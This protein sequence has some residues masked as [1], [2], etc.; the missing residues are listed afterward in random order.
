MKSY[1]QLFKQAKNAGTEL[2]LLSEKKINELLELIAQKTEKNI[3][4][5]LS[6]N[7]K[8]LEKMDPILPKYDRLLLNEQR[9]TD[10][11]SD[12]HKV[13]SLPYPVGKI[14]AKRKLD[15]GLQLSKISV[16]FGVIGIIFESRPNVCFDVFSL[17]LKSGNACILKG[18]SE[19][20]YSN[21][22]ISEII[23]STLKEKNINPD[24]CTL[25]PNDRSATEQLLTAREYVDLII[26]RGGKELINF[27][28][29]NS[30]IP[31]IETGAGVCHTYFHQEG[32]KE[33]GKNIIT[34]AKTRKVSVCN[35]LDCLIIDKYRLPDLAY[36]CKDLMKQNVLIYADDLAY[37]NLLN[38]YPNELLKK[39]N[40][41][42]YGTEF[43]DYKMSIK[44]V[45]SINEAINHIN[46]Y[47]SRHSEAIISEN[48][49]AIKLF[50]RRV[51]AACVYINA[52]TAFTDGSQL[53]WGAEIGI[54]TQKMHARGPMALEELCTYKWIIQGNGQIR[55]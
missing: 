35:S 46:L 55:R 38:Q 54:S 42:S 5:I 4:K 26:P 47:G 48:K 21:A 20:A 27:V 12:L 41:K 39:V 10:I 16:P 2:N 1:I 11:I 40:S 25:L 24:I 49:E 15:N 45:E 18:G 14:I 7:Q 30:L 43:L 36:L 31:I 23:R 28:R 32:N 34:N 19:A 44:T 17:C 53:G 37:E 8:D 33:I 51:D 52:S 13:K 50:E 9:I 3:T 29:E 6:E 22:I